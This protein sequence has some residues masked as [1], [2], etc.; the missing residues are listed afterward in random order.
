MALTQKIFV[1]PTA[2]SW[3][4][5]LV[6]KVLRTYNLEVPVRQSDLAAEPLFY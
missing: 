6:K 5:E 1:S 3:F 4:S 2:K